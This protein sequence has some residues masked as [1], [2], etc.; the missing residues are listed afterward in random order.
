MDQVAVCSNKACK[1]SFV[2]TLYRGKPRKTC[3]VCI[4]QKN[5]WR[6]SA[7]GKAKMAA[8]AK[9]DAVKTSQQKYK[10]TDVGKAKMYAS[11]SKYQ[12]SE[13][14]KAAHKRYWQSD[15][16][17]A[18]RREP[19]HRL[20]GRITNMLGAGG[21]R[22]HVSATLKKFTEI[23][24]RD[25]LRAHIESTMEPWMNWSN[26]GLHVKGAPYGAKWQLGHRIPCYEYDHSSAEDIR[27]CHLLANIYAQ[28]SRENCEMNKKIPL[29]QK[30]QGMKAVWPLAW[31]SEASSSRVTI[32][33]FDSE[34]ESESE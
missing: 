6:R 13:K 34:S 28:D 33:M 19:I 18:V 16:G 4:N 32:D 11:N 15:K 7:S 8:Y 24:T 31:C 26:Y 2:V 14:G 29:D 22:K 23:H 21:S 12:S 3:P 27:R 30:L 10:A 5:T 25:Q 17:I 20:R 9:T 1:K